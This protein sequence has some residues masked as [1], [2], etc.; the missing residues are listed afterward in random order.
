MVST[1][2]R[3]AAVGYPVEKFTDARDADTATLLTSRG[4]AA[5][6]E[7]VS[8]SGFSLTLAETDNFRYGGDGVHVGDMVT[9]D[10]GAA[11][12]TDILREATLSF[13]S[14]KGLSITPTVGEIQDS[15]DRQVAN[16][17]KSLRKGIAQL[18]AGK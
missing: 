14:D 17:L 11:T 18:R 8:K 15:P 12:R 2:G 7:G 10:I 6:D 1:D 3:E 16:F 5:L 13:T 4:Q 9:V